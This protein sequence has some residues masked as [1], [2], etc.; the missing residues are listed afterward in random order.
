MVLE[1]S[2]GDIAAASSATGM[3]ST[4]PDFRRLTL[5]PMKAPG[6]LLS[7]ATSIWSREI[8]VGLFCPAIL[9]AV[10]PALTVIFVS[11]FPALGAGGVAAGV[12]LGAGV[13]A[14]GAGCAMG[15]AGGCE[16]GLDGALGGD[17]M[18]AVGATASDVGACRRLGGSNSM[19]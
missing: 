15:V 3:S 5:P 1:A 7:S 11:S 13:A 18:G 9:P 2:E 17:M 12:D 8:L 10:S 4:A 6:L 19:V 14:R 16:V